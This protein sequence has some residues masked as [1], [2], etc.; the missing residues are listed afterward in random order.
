[1]KSEFPSTSEVLDST[2]KSPS[3]HF[4]AGCWMITFWRSSCH[5][6]SFALHITLSPLSTSDFPVSEEVPFWRRSLI[7]RRFRRTRDATFQ[8]Y[9]DLRGETKFSGSFNGKTRIGDVFDSYYND[10]TQRFPYSCGSFKRFPRFVLLKSTTMIEFQAAGFRGVSNVIS[11]FRGVLHSSFRRSSSMQYNNF[12]LARVTIDSVDHWWNPR[13]RFLLWKS[14]RILDIQIPDSKCN[15]GVG[16]CI[17]P[18]YQ[19]QQEFW[20]MQYSSPSF[21][22]QEEF[23]KLQCSIPRFQVQQEFWILQF[24]SPW[25]FWIHYTLDV[26]AATSSAVLYI[27]FPC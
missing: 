3:C 4:H 24:I 11:N 26:Q 27:I 6:L 19:V 14:F 7:Q 1:M 9:P 2:F 10:M 8:H 5:F 23:W 16:Y 18:S 13:R 17:S 12:S 15:K 25:F 22:V 21:Q 20:I